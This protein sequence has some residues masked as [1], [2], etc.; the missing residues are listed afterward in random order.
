MALFA[1]GVIGGLYLTVYLLKRKLGIYGS[2]LVDLNNSRYVV[3][4]ELIGG[5]KDIKMLGREASYLNR[6]ES[7]SYKFAHVSAFGAIIKQLPS[8]LIAIAFGTIVG[9]TVVLMVTSD[10]SDGQALGKILPTLGV[11]AFAAYRMKPAI[12]G[13]YKG[14][15]SLKYGSCYRLNPFRLTQDGKLRSFVTE[16]SLFRL[17]KSI[18][19]D[20]ISYQ[21]PSSRKPSLRELNLRIDVGSTV[22]IVGSTGA[23]K[24]LIDIFLGLLAHGGQILVDG[25]QLTDE[26]RRN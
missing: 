16:K 14:V 23:G 1:I 8:Y 5:I 4:T 6:F 10:G 3:A 20:D 9:L 24:P 25:V 19:F 13:I 7:L 12:Q 21:Y 18:I 15:S 22:G 11:Y 17:G 2:A 26:N